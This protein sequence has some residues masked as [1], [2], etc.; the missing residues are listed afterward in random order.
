[1]VKERKERER[2]I[3]ERTRLRCERR[4]KK[5]GMLWDPVEK[6]NNPQHPYNREG[7]QGDG[8]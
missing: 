1:M 6:S 7:G 3:C 4:G 8:Q 2:D 5:R